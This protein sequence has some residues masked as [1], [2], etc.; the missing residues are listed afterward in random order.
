MSAV[1]PGPPQPRTGARV[2][3]LD[4]NGCVL[5]I[6]E[7]IEPGTHW[8]TPGGGV[9]PGEQL[10]QAAARELYEE[11]GLQ[12]TISAADLPVHERQRLWHWRGASYDQRDH[13]FVVRV[14]PRPEITPAGLTS[15]EQET[16]LEMRWWSAADLHDAGDEVIEPPDLA[17]VLDRIA[18]TTSPRA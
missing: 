18:R 11:T 13:F 6:H 14:D 15:M 16:L 7:R 10:S 8:L 2:L 5:L 9:E 17:A 3:L 4:P 1:V 12:V